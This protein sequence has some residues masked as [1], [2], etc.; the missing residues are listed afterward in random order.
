MKIYN[1]TYDHPEYGDCE[2]QVGYESSKKE[3]C[4]YYVTTNNKKFQKDIDHDSRN[5][6]SEFAD[7]ILNQW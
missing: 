5:Y 6:F 1:T 4:V 2:V 7:D 3:I